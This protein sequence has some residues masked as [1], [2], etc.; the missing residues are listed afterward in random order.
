MSPGSTQRVHDARSPHQSRRKLS[1]LALVDQA[2]APVR[3]LVEGES[4]TDELFLRIARAS[5]S[6]VAVLDEARTH[7][8]LNHSVKKDEFPLSVLLD[9]AKIIVWRADAKSSRFTYVSKQAKKMLGYPTSH[10]YEPDFLTLHLHPEDQCRVLHCFGNHAEFGDCYDLTFRMLAKDGRVVWLRNLVTI[11]RNGDDPNNV[12]G[13]MIDVTDRRR[14]EEAWL[15]LSRR[16]ITTQEYEC[17]RIARELHDDFNQRMALLSIE[18]EQLG[19]GIPEVGDQEL[20]EKLKRQVQEISADIHRLSYRLHPSK[21]DHLGLSAAVKSLCEE[22]SHSAKLKIAYQSVGF[23]STLPKDLELCLFRIVQ[24]SL[25]NCIKHSGAKSIQVV[26]ARTRNDVR[27]SISD[28]GNGFDKKA[29]TMRKGLGFLSMRERLNLVN[30]EMH[31]YSQPRRGT[32]IEVLVPLGS[33]T[34]SSGDD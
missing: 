6:N 16:L 19:K 7:L 27:L 31:V 12:Y 1:T 23:P 26:L 8:S 24:E 15:D 20:C 33:E 14:A 32:R 4:L 25:R 5:A 11:E 3:R 18:L 2:P 17:G 34:K 10:W 29:E 30:G 21:L 28:N 13:F 9:T 22:L